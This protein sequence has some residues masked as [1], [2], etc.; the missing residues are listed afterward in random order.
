MFEGVTLPFTTGEIVTGAMDLIKVL[1]P[2][3]AIALALVLAPRLIK[4]IKGALGG[5]GRT[6]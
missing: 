5:G 1:G 6:A 3:V 2:V 4:I